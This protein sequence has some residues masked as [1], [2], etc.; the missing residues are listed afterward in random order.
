MLHGDGGFVE[1]DG[2]SFVVKSFRSVSRVHEDPVPPPPP[3]PPVPAAPLD[4]PVPNPTSIPPPAPQPARASTDLQRYE[5]RESHHQQESLRTSVDLG[6]ASAPAR[7]PRRPSLATLGNGRPSSQA[8]DRDGPGTIPAE[9][10]RAASARSRSAVSLASMDSPP[11]EASRPRF[12]PQRPQSRASRRGSSYSEAGSSVLVPPRPSFAIGQHSNGSGSSIDSRSSSTSNV[13]AT[14]PATTT[15][16]IPYDPQISPSSPVSRSRLSLS[17]TSREGESAT[18]ERPRLA[19]RM[20]S[21]DSEIRL[22][23]AYGDMLTA[24]PPLS[25]S[26][27]SQERTLPLVE[28]PESVYEPARS[29][30]SSEDPPRPRI[31]T[32]PFA[33]APSPERAPSFAIQPPTPQAQTELPFNRPRRTSSLQPDSVAQ[34]LEAMGLRQPA[35]RSRPNVGGKGKASAVGGAGAGWTSDT[36]DD[37]MERLST[38]DDEF[39]DEVPLATIR[40]RS[41]TDLASMAGGLRSKTSFETT[42]SARPTSH[43][44]VPVPAS[45]APPAASQQQRRMS[46]ASLG[47]APALQRRVSDRRSMSTLSFSTSMTASQAASRPNLAPAGTPAQSQRPP[48]QSNPSTATMPSLASTSTV[49]SSTLPSALPSPL[50]KSDSRNRS[51][52]SSASATTASSFPHTPKDRSPETSVLGIDTQSLFPPSQASASGPKPAVKFNLATAR[53]TIGEPR[54]GRLSMLGAA[55]VSTPNL[56]PASSA[57]ELAPPVPSVRANPSYLQHSGQAAAR[58]TSSVASAREP[59]PAAA[60]GTVNDRLKARHRAEALRAMQIGRDLNDPSGVVPDSEAQEALL[61]GDGSDENEPLANLPS[62]GS[63]LGGMSGMGGYGPMGGLPGMGM[64]GQYS[65]LAVPPPGVDPYLCAYR[66]CA[67]YRRRT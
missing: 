9:A 47:A 67:C 56:L 19:K 64:G 3:V 36:S 39:E 57:S 13:I 31:V 12:E 24:S 38:S 28:E 41:Q 20:S 23:A 60:A 35:A 22:I 25:A 7:Q 37:D 52:A 49:G 21:G 33:S 5:S 61:G 63:M 29:V 26:S 59:A 66:V 27:P 53:S 17:S 48:Y 42:R 32:N 11:L 65:Q 1:D 54:S 10:F 62:H 2:S 44:E 40:S 51:S 16:A 46:Q 58:E 34:A 43:Q 55:S 6:T 50:L 30:L 8:C 45:R 18:V 14:S 4:L 15:S